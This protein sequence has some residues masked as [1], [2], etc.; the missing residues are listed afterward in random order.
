MKSLVVI[1]TYNEAANIRKVIE[2][3][4]SVDENVEVL[5]VD[6]NSPDHTGSIVEEAFADNPRVHQLSRNRKMGLGTAYIEGFKWAVPGDYDFIFE[7]DADLSHDPNEIPHFL[8]AA[9]DADLVIGSRYVEGGGVVNWPIRRL[10]LSYGANLYARLV[11]GLP[12]YDCTSGFKCFHREVL[13]NLGL[14]S[15]HS[16]GYSFQIEMNYRVWKKGF[17]IKEIPVIFVDRTVG[18]SKMSRAIILEAVWIVWKLKLSSLLRRF[19]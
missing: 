5:V 8:E 19:R 12:V 11:T 7:M 14:D 3:T 13:E 9:R 2:K 10:I 18:Q 6:D 17:R 4:L 1:P 16:D 15:F